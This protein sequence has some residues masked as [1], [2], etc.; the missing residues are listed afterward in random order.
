MK[1][2]LS[3]FLQN[4]KAPLETDM[5]QYKKLLEKIDSIKL[6]T[7]GDHRLKELSRIL[8]DKV[9]SGASEGELLP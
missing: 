1:N 6:D 2:R 4:I 5:E 3:A 8:K 9:H 7:A